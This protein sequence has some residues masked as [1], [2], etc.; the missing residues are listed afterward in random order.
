M[1]SRWFRFSSNADESLEGGGLQTP[2]VGRRRTR[3]I[4]R[5]QHACSAEPLPL[6]DLGSD[7]SPFGEVQ[8]LKIYKMLPERQEDG[9]Y[10]GVVS[11]P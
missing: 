10:G 11:V 2:A 4:P 9:A 3:A 6:G 7:S 5:V 8:V 1:P